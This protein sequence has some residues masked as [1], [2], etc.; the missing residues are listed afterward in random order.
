MS[1]KIDAYSKSVDVYPLVKYYMDELSLFELFKKYVPKGDAELEPAEGLCI[2]IVNILTANHPLYKV[3]EWL[4]NYADGISEAVQ[5]AAKYNDDRL[6]RCCL[7]GLYKADRNTLLTEISAIAI[8]VHEL[9][10]NILHNDTTSLTLHGAYDNSSNTDGIKP[11]RGYNKDGHPDCKQIVFGL[12][13]TEDGNVPISYTAYNG[14]TSD[15]E[16]HIPNW[17]KLRELLSKEEFIYV[18]DSKG[19][20]MENLS[21]IA[22]HGGQFISVL[23]ATR[24]EVK[25]FHNRLKNKEVIWLSGLSQENS[26]KKGDFTTYQTFETTSREGYRII[27]VLSSTKALQ[28]ARQRQQKIATAWQKLQTLESKLNRYKLKTLAQIQKAVDKALEGVGE[29]VFCQITEHTTTIKKQIGRG[30]AGPNTRY[31]DIAQTSY[32]LSFQCNIPAIKEA[33]GT[34]GIFPL[35]SNCDLSAVEVLRTYKQQPYLEKRHSTLKTVEQVCPIYLKKPQRIEA[36]LFLY[37]VALMIISLMERNIRNQM[38]QPM[39]ST[40]VLQPV[41]SSLDIKTV[42]L[43]EPE[44]FVEQTTNKNPA[45]WTKEPKS[46]LKQADT[47]PEIKSKSSYL[48]L[49]QK[50][51]AWPKNQS[52]YTSNEQMISSPKLSK[53]VIPSSPVSLPILPQGMKTETPTWG[54]IKYLFRNVYQVVITSG[55]S[56]LRR[57]LK[58]MTSLHFHVLELL[59]VLASV[60]DNLEGPW[61]RFS[62]G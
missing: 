21:H 59:G 30:K 45:S 13:V 17:D 16:T 35:I 40:L 2:Q 62:N 6:G 33:A 28:D 5:N 15:S 19:A 25:D 37:F 48:P 58:G 57:V 41:L 50:S 29:Y 12:N 60:Y 42:L 24:L 44:V 52:F 38:L 3:E 18:T 7:D 14:N 39:L 46:V 51:P 1:N 43:K 9:E 53:K 47:L 61:W 49:D 32:A 36:M 55:E 11:A 56:I 23:P 10:T 22:R 26:R 8:K 4:A 27:W 20:N 54:N 34:D 31:Q